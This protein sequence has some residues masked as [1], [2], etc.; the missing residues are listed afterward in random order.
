MG[1]RILTRRAGLLVLVAAIA[2]GV[3][4]V[5]AGPAAAYPQYVHGGATC[6]ICHGTN[7]PSSPPASNDV[8]TT[9]HTGGF[10]ALAV[11][12]T[13]AD[14]TCWGCHT[15]GEDMSFVT[16]TATSCGTAGAAAGC[17]GSASPHPGATATGCTT[18]HALGAVSP[19][20]PGTSP[21]HDP[22]ATSM[23]VLTVALSKSTIKV[24]TSIKASGLAYPAAL[25]KVTV[26]VQKKSGTKWVKVTSKAVTPTAASAWSYSY[27]A[28][29]K[30]SYRVQASTPAV[31]GVTAGLVTSKTFKVK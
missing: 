5:V 10:V 16:A 6:L 21:H 26:L 7:T 18:C 24:K 8:C 23:P 3:F 15:P 2:V 11:A 9:C 17:H 27:K 25:G 30:G 4:A 19:T 14:G 31:T 12:G 28:T 20:N 1:K 29:K 13:S 22:S